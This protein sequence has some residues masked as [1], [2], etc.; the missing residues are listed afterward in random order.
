MAD[1]LGGCGGAALVSE[2]F[3]LRPA[4]ASHERPLRL[5]ELRVFRTGRAEVRLGPGADEIVEKIPLQ[6]DPLAHDREIGFEMFIPHAEIDE[7]PIP[8]CIH[9][10][11]FIYQVW[12]VAQELVEIVRVRTRVPSPAS[13]SYMLVVEMPRIVKSTQYAAK[14]ISDNGKSKR[15]L[16][17]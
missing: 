11:V 17:P 9:A 13:L 16:S 15:G 8:F 6:P 4:E 3:D 10:P 7:H 5:I 14:R 1:R 12:M 2:H